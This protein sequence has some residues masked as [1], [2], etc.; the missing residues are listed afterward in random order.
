[1]TTGF[2]A[3]LTATLA[4]GFVEGLGHFY[5]SRQTWMRLRRIRGRLPMVRMRQRFEASA[6][7]RTVRLLAL[8]LAI[9]VVAWIAAASLLDKRWHEVLLD[10]LPYV[11]VGLALV[12]TPVAM[13]SIA[14]RM[15]RFEEEFGDDLEDDWDGSE[16]PRGEIA[17]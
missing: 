12:R 17:L 9:L 15:K 16:P 13:R 7:K 11:I 4:L 1:M 10:V 2:I 3:A 6:S 14:E 5:P 8:L